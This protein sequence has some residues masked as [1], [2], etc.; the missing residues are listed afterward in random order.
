MSDS[1]HVVVLLSGGL[2]STTLA[3]LAMRDGRLAFVLSFY[4]GQPAAMWEGHA[5][6]EWARKHGITRNVVTVEYPDT[7]PMELG[8]GVKGPRVLPGRNLL[9]CSYGVAWAAAWGAKEVWIGACADD[10]ANYP[11]CRGQFLADLSRASEAYGVTVRAPFLSYTKAGIVALARELGVDI[12]ATWS[13]YEPGRSEKPCGKC[14][15]CV[16]RASVLS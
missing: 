6:G 5:A 15:A 3:H 4:Y 12:D 7:T 1:P 9:L 11:D 2:D 10:Y 8:E 14:N 16:L 13:C